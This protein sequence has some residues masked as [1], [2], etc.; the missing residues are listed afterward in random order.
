M[1]VIQCGEEYDKNKSTLNIGVKAH[2]MTLKL[3]RACLKRED[4]IGVYLWVI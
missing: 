3:R 1:I 4:M 2:S